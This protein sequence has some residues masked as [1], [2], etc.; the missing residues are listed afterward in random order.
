MTFFAWEERRSVE[1]PISGNSPKKSVHSIYQITRFLNSNRTFKLT[2]CLISPIKVFILPLNVQILNR[3]AKNAVRFRIILL[4][5]LQRIPFVKQV[6]NVGRLLM[7]LEGESIEIGKWVKSPSI[8]LIAWHNFQTLVFHLCIVTDTGLRS[9]LLYQDKDSYCQLS[10]C[11][12]Q[13]CSRQS[14][15]EQRT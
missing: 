12:R 3:V 5:Q 2:C 4:Y 7:F 10:R 13:C 15:D 1:G 6:K 9:F 14:L 8:Y 11:R